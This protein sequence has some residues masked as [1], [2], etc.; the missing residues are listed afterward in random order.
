MTRKDYILIARAV[1]KTYRDCDNHAG[2][3]W[4]ALDKLVANLAIALADDNPRFN[5]TIFGLA[6]GLPATESTP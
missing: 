5:R 6:C 3:A 1:S 4:F 2:D